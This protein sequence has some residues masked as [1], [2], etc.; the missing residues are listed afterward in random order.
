MEH[1]GS[2]RAEE[3]KDG[4]ERDGVVCAEPRVCVAFQGY[5]R[6]LYS[7]G[8]SLWNDL[9]S[10]ELCGKLTFFGDIW[11]LIGRNLGCLQCEKSTYL[12]IRYT[13]VCSLTEACCIV[14]E[15]SQSENRIV[16]R[17]YVVQLHSV[18]RRRARTKDEARDRTPFNLQ[19]SMFKC[20]RG[21]RQRSHSH[22]D[23]MSLS[24][25][26][27]VKR[28]VCADR[29]GLGTPELLRSPVA[30]QHV[31]VTCTCTCACALCTR[32]PTSTTPWATLTHFSSAFHG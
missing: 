15:N 10:C 13:N 14:H 7:A 11:C 2:T 1:G 17:R 29:T 19:S 4:G 22:S 20:H 9:L 8:G 23:S 32:P 3:R 21:P 18:F 28:T 16:V 31:H 26:R 12:D 24:E 25:S 6:L 27:S 30:V 5:T